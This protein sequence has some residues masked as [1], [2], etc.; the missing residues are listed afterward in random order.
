MVALLGILVVASQTALGD[1][2]KQQLP[3]NIGDL[4]Q[5]QVMEV[6]DAAGI[7][8]LTG[9]FN[10]KEDDSN[11]LDREAPLRGRTGYG[12]AEVEISKKNGQVVDQE[13]EVQIKDLRADTPY[14]IFMDRKEVFSFTSDKKGKADLLFSTKVKS[15]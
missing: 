7:V 3:S 14:K 15:K 8:A 4:Q 9:K 6:R 2:I 13:L 12:K 10:T 5:V 11:E 1:R